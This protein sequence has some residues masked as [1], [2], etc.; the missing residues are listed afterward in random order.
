M[1]TNTD[2]FLY[3]DFRRT[4]DLRFLVEY[5]PDPPDHY[6]Y[7]LNICPQLVT[8]PPT[9]PDFPHFSLLTLCLSSFL[10]FHIYI[11]IYFFFHFSPSL[12]LFSPLSRLL[13]P[14]FTLTLSLLSTQSRLSLLHSH[15]LTK[16]SQS[17]THTAPRL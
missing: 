16:Y 13:S 7:P 4:T 5:P 9:H 14:T 17:W 11:Y 8:H 15:D 6:T 1:D 12:S 10:S 3:S 2:F